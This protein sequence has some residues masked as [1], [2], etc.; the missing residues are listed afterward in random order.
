[1]KLNK[2]TSSSADSGI[3]GIR[4]IERREWWLWFLV[5][6]VTL[7][8]TGGI[9][10][11]AL[12]FL[13][14]QSDEFYSVH[15]RQSVSGLLGLVLI[16]DIYSLYQQFQIYSVR[17]QLFARDELFRVITENVADMI[18]VVDEQGNRIYNSPAYRKILG[19]SP[20]ELK[21]TSSL[22]QVHP[23]DRLRVQ[24]AAAQARKS[25]QSETLEYRMRHKDG[26]WRV[27]ESIASML[28]DSTGASAKLVVLNRD[29]TERKRMEE[30]LQHNAFHDPLT[31]LPNRALF[32]DRLGHALNRAKRRTD[33][34]F[35]VLLVDIDDFKKVNDSLGHSAGDKVLTEMAERLSRS[36]RKE[37]EVSRHKS[38]DFKLSEMSDTLAR[39]GGDEFTILL[40][41][42]AN[43]GDAMGVARRIQEVLAATPF[44]VGEREIFASVS[45]GIAIL[46]A[47]HRTPEDLVRDADTAMYRAKASGKGCC[48]VFDPA[49]HNFALQRLNVETA[50]RKAV[51]NH[52]F[53][54]VYQP[55]V[56]LR[57]TR[58]VGFEALVRWD[59]PG[60]G[61]LPPSEFIGVAEESGLIIPINYNLRLEACGTICSWQRQF[62]CDPPLAL[63]LNV[64]ARELAHPGL[65]QDID[66]ALRSTGL[67]PA[68]LSLEVLETFI[69]REG[70][71]QRVLAQAKA[72]GVRLSIDDFGSGYS[73]LGRLRQLSADSLKIDRNFVSRLHIDVG[74]RSIVET[75][76]ALAH[77][78]GLQVVAEGAETLDE[79]NTLL[80]MNCEYAQGYYFSRPMLKD[81]AAQM[82][83][84]ELASAR[85]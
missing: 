38:L 13:S 52:E 34:R 58:I 3:P 41:D 28:P 20:Q 45:V 15:I 84:A 69:M 37:D 23:D 53:R 8:L 46:S 26:T 30:Q 36:V 77:N 47:S 59:R 49:M 16:F 35:A 24:R 68:F 83:Q 42:I 5:V 19:Y 43:A 9:T 71:P 78:F 56:R 70:D 73:S 18:A 6:I 74:N 40:E 44:R 2:A 64:S 57:D 10:V 33:Y 80:E 25:G 4:H 62:H 67:P 7:L 31:G 75:I 72:L 81:A 21:S 51:E 50:L 66:E 1:M 79:V 29:V 14:G 54:V 39:L 55:V 76:I 32:L 11:L 27:L 82:L 63:S 22:E 85:S 65:I 61:L 12:A 17:R 48:A 60:V